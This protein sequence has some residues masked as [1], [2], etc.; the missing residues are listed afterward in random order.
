MLLKRDKIILQKVFEEITYLETTLKGFTL[1]TFI[2]N[3]DKKRVAA[4]TLLNMGELVKNLSIEFI[5]SARSF[6]L[7][8]MRGLRHIAAHEYYALRFNDIWETIQNDIPSLKKQVQ[9]F[10]AD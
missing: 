4:M 10:L 6:P 7:K 1:E 2:A 5:Q 8:E 9:D 3:E